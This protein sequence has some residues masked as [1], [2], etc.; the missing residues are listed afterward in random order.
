MSV[1][2]Q[3]KQ[4]VNYQ[5]NATG[6]I[7]FSNVQ[8]HTDAIA[9]LEKL[10]SDVEQSIQSGILDEGVSLDIEYRLK[11]AILQAKKAEPDKKTIL[12]HLNEAKSLIEGVAAATGLV[13]AL[14]QAVT[15]IQKVF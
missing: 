10:Y 8:N 6:N 12:E 15:M 13:T 9:E 7:N 1:F 4:T 2:D 3:R 5:Y 11:K 14:A